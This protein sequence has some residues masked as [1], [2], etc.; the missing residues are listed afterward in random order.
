MT[1]DE[2]IFRVRQQGLHKNNI[3]SKVNNQSTY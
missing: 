3:K 2:Y 1:D